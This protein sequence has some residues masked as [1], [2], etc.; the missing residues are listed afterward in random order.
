MVNDDQF[1]QQCQEIGEKIT[2]V[3]F[4]APKPVAVCVLPA[5]LAAVMRTLDIPRETI[6]AMLDSALE[7]IDAG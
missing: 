6:I 4:E 1:A 3:L 2:D 7:D 5:V